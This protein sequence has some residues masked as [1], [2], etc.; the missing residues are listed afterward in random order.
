MYYHKFPT[1]GIGQR[2]SYTTSGGIA[3]PTVVF[4]VNYDYN[5]MLNA[6]PNA[7]SGTEQQRNAVATLVYHAGLVLKMNY[8]V[9]GSGPFTFHAREIVDYL[10]YDRSI[11]FLF[12]SYFNTDA[13]WD[14]IIK[15]QLD[16]GFPVM[17]T[18]NNSAG[19]NS[20]SVI[21]DGYDSA[22]KFHINIWLWR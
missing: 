17:Y 14:A 9:D 13:E 10:G 20:H 16:D 8:A 12:R 6:Y 3:V 4:N 2:D 22:G 11:Q 15:K 5:N 21:V 19:N 7:T 18:G 1:R